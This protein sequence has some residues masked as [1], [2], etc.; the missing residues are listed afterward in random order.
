MML[1]RQAM[2]ETYNDNDVY[3]TL[4]HS[5]NQPQART[6]DPNELAVMSQT[7]NESVREKVKLASQ[8][9]KLPK[10]VKKVDGPYVSGMSQEKRFMAVCS[11]D[12]HI[13]AT[14]NGFAR[15]PL[16]GFYCH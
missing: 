10:L 12:A 16:G 6:I 1:L 15:T 11:N 8:S 7:I 13:K 14:N 9:K 3:G 2:H 5:R 4:A